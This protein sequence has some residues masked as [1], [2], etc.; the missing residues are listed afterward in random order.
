MRLPI[1]D[2]NLKSEQYP[3]NLDH[4]SGN[5]IGL[6]VFPATYYRGMR[7]TSATAHLARAPNNLVVMTDS[8]ATRIHFEGKQAM[9]VELENGQIGMAIS[10][11]RRNHD[12]RVLILNSVALARKEVILAAGAFDSPKLLLLS[13]IGPVSQLKSH[14]IPI[15]HELQGVGKNLQEH[16]IVFLNV[17]VDSALS[18]KYAFEAD[19]VAMK[20]ARETWVKDKTGPLS[21]HNGTVWGGFLKL[22][23]LENSE[24]YKELDSDVRTY[25]E[26]P[27]VPAFETALSAPMLP[28]GHELPKGHAY[29]TDVVFLMNPQSRGH[30]TLA[31]D[32]PKDAPLIDIGFLSHAFDRKAMLLAIRESMNFFEK[33]ALA[34]YFKGYILGPKSSSDEDINVNCFSSSDW[35]MLTCM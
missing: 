14:N 27:T 26:K 6:G 35:M 12:S 5:P 20:E 33:S 32:N 24:E 11:G 9:G 17:E 18:E 4:N 13:G 8:A 30:I 29:L 22:P 7:T 23:D 10:R 28:P 2:M 25:M 31:S 21:H 19:P 34:K 3:R 16:P 1:A 15:V